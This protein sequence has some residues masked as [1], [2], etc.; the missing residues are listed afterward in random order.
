MKTYPFFLLI[1]LSFSSCSDEEA[2]LTFEQKIEGRWHGIFM[3]PDCCTFELDIK[4]D[5]LDV[6]QKSAAGNYSNRDN[7]TCNDNFFDCEIIQQNGVYCTTNW[8]FT[9]SDGTAATFE[10]TV[11]E[12]DICAS[13]IITIRLINDEEIRLNWVDTQHAD[14]TATATLARQ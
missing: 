2:S 7:S 1:L 3:Q 9:A 14:N 13:G 12:N 4:F 6:G 10:E 5:N 8:V 11:V